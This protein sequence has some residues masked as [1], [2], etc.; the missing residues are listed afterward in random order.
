MIK[1]KIVLFIAPLLLCMSCGKNAGNAKS[2]VMESQKESQ[3]VQHIPLSEVNADSAYRFVA[4]QVA[5]GPRVP[6]TDAHRACGDYLVEKL[7]EYGAVVEEQKGEARL[8]NGQPMA[9][10]NIIGRYFP[11]AKRRVLLCA[12]WDT[13]PFADQESDS[14]YWNTAID[15]AKDRKSVV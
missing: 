13:R 1:K 6:G 8:Y 7:T 9:L 2:S 12:H 11:E 5:F 4:E 10:R 14:K 3:T 15:G